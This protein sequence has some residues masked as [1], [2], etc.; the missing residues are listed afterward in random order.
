MT[1][2]DSP[3]PRWTVSAVATTLRFG[4]DEW[5]TMIWKGGRTTTAEDGVRIPL[6]VEVH[7]AEHHW[8][9]LRLRVRWWRFSD[10]FVLLSLVDLAI[11]PNHPEHEL[12]PE[13]LS[14]SEW[15][16]TVFAVTTDHL[17]RTVREFDPG[18]REV[19]EPWYGWAT[20]PMIPPRSARFIFPADGGA[21]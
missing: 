13:L 21:T 14:E 8:F 6:S 15:W 1:G 19:A 9:R 20:G 12:P 7:D 18:Y 11:V 3:E 17:F 10:N 16:A 5:P 4:E 2:E